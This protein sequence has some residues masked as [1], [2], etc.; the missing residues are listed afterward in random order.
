MKEL[1]SFLGLVGYYHHYIE[2]FSKIVIPL[3][4]LTRNDVKFVW[5]EDCKKC[6][7]ELKEWLVTASILTIPME[8][9]K[10]VIY[11]NSSKN[12]LGC[13]LMQNGKVIAYVSRQLKDYER[14]YPT[15]DL[16]LAVV[17]FAWKLWRHYLYGERC[18]IYTHH[19]VSNISL[20][21]RI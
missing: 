10:F 20:L 19:K 9:G 2:R 11:R 8:T 12:G 5:T 14:N 6:F 18:K 7:Q 1:R 17:V 13:V 3:T 16:E 21:K 4:R 15:H